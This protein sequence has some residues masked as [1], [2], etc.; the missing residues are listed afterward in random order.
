M[1]IIFDFDG[2]IHK[3]D[4]IYE[5]AFYQTLKKYKIKK[6]NLDPKSYLGYPPR[7]IWDDFLDNSYDKEKLIE[8]TGKFMIENM[9]DFGSLYRDTKKV[10]N[11]LKK[12]HELIILSSCPRKYIDTAIKFYKLDLYFSKYLIGEDYDYKEKSEI[13]KINKIDN[14]IIIGDRKSD[15]EAGYL[16]DN[17]SIFAKYG[18][19]KKGEGNLADYK[20]DKISDLLKIKALS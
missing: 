5:K 15:I 20:I 18:Y 17:I 2:T 8:T 4:E 10:L 13:I 12:K 11:I 19:A 1:K 14:F 7:K 9:K 16:N 3:S 6:P